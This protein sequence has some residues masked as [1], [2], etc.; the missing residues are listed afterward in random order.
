M[1]L[2][3]YENRYRPSRLSFEYEVLSVN[4]GMFFTILHTTNGVYVFGDNTSGQLGLGNN[5]RRQNIPIK[6]LFDY[7]VISIHCGHSHTVLN[8]TDGLYVFG[9]NEYG[10]LGLDKNIQYQSTPKKLELFDLSVEKIHCK[11]I[12]TTLL[13]TN[14]YYV[15]GAGRYLNLNSNDPIKLSI[16]FDIIEPQ[17]KQRMI[18]S[19][20]SRK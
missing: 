5:I 17:N 14:G 8:T 6:L 20:R 19:A 9:N 15:F 1:G 3:D 2:G 12:Q 16:N 10:Q 4:Y 13:T 7:D 18:K 11:G